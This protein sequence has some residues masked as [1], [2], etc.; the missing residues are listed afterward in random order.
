MCYFVENNMDNAE[1]VVTMLLVIN[2]L[3]TEYS[4]FVSS[5]MFEQEYVTKKA[6][7]GL[8]TYDSTEEEVSELHKVFTGGDNSQNIYNFI[9]LK[10]GAKR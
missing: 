8:V 2:M 6:I 5:T 1:L 9:A 7:L 4:F 3:L 10:C